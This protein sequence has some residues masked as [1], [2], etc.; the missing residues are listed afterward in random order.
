MKMASQLFDAVSQVGGEFDAAVEVLAEQFRQVLLV[1]RHAAFVE[2][3]D[4]CLVVVDADDSV[5]DLSKTD[6][7]DE[8][9]VP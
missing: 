1:D 6:C 4:L 9:D 7:G 3:F 2:H 8:S 5:A